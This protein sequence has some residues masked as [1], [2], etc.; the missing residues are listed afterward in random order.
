MANVIHSASDIGQF[1]TAVLASAARTATPD[2]QEFELPRDCSGLY[3]V[4]DITALTSTGTLDV[5]LDAVDRVSGKTFT[6]ADSGSL[7]ATGTTVL[8][9]GPSLPATG[10]VGDVVVNAIVPDV[11]RVTATHGNS[12]SLTYSIGLQIS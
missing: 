11:I 12:V 6:L 2:T 1:G 9:V 7:T 10:G 4:V 5:S 3:L 8:T